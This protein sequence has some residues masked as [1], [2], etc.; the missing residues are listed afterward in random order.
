MDLT[1]LA[2]ANRSIAESQKRIDE[3]RARIERRERDG[4]DS[5][6]ARELLLL[7]EEALALMIDH[8]RAILLCLKCRSR[9]KH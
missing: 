8:R 3:L 1:H 5:S 7:C 6:N 2:D 4:R 9:L